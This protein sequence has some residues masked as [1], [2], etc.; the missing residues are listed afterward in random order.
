MEK[1]GGEAVKLAVLCFG[2]EQVNDFLAQVLYFLAGSHLL[3]E[4]AVDLADLALY[5]PQNALP[6]DLLLEAQTRVLVEL[7]DELLEVQGKVHYF[8]QC[9]LSFLALLPAFSLLV[10]RDQHCKRCVELLEVLASDEV[11]VLLEVVGH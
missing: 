7:S 10:E 3:S 4:L 2:V 8:A 11:A 6:G 1:S 9:G 5:L